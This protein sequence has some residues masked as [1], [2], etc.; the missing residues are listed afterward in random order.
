MRVII[1]HKCMSKHQTV[2]L[3]NKIILHNLNFKIS[4]KND[5]QE[6]S[7]EASRNSTHHFRTAPLWTHCLWD[8]HSGHL[9][10]WLDV[11]TR[12]PPTLCAVLCLIAQA[13]T[14]LCNPVD[15]SPPGSSVHG[16]LQSRITEWVAMASS[17]VSSQPRDQIKVSRIAGRFFTVWAG[18]PM[19]TAVGSLSLLQG[20]FPIQELNQGLLRFR[21]I[22]YQLTRD[23]P[24]PQYSP[25]NGLCAQLASSCHFTSKSHLC[26][27][28]IYWGCHRPLLSSKEV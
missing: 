3:K 11:N 9:V 26:L 13:C 10:H 4:L 1:S 24:P 14:T 2:Y 17:R 27:H 7:Y 8:I 22:P 23:T 20:V 18:K 19:N 16:I 21:Q 12:N 6:D 28:L 5:I 25:G 15:C